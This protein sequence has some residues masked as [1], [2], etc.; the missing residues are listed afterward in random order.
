MA[1]RMEMLPGQTAFLASAVL[2]LKR[3]NIT[4]W[5]I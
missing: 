5:G 1:V 3:M 2:L 4:F